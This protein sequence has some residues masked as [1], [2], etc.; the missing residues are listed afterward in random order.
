MKRINSI[1][2][3]TGAFLVFLMTLLIAA[4]IIGR[5]LGY[6]LPGA[7]NLAGFMLAAVTFL[8]LSHCEE[9]GGHVRVEVVLHR[10][11]PK[12]RRL[13]LL[14]NLLVAL[15]IYGFMAWGSGIDTI[16]AWRLLQMIPGAVS[17]PVYPSKTIVTIGC[18]L[19]CIQLALNIIGLFGKRWKES[20]AETISAEVEKGR[21]DI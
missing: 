6:P 5:K 20:L 13:L 7:V 18:G 3:V 17:L 1:A 19:M 4:N 16:E 8:G 10:L 2:A 15:F 14:F 21:E 11:T 12:N 9:V